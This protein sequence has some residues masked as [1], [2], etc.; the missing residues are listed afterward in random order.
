MTRVDFKK[1]IHYGGRREVREGR[2]MFTNK[3]S[4]LQIPKEMV[5]WQIEF[6]TY[7]TKRGKRTI[8]VKLF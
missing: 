4:D 8:N 2:E 5:W 7:L 1:V 6:V 3:I